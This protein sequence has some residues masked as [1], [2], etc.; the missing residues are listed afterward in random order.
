[1][2]KLNHIAF[3]MDG[4]GRWGEKKKRGRNFGHV[5]GV[6]TIK[7]IVNISKIF[8]ITYNDAEK[9]KKSFNKSETEF[10]YTGKSKNNVITVNEIINKKISINLLKKVILYRIQEIIDLHFKLSN[11]KNYNINLK[12]T[13]LF[14]IGDGSILFDNNSFYLDNKF[15]FK[16]INYFSETDSQI[17]LSA[18]AQYL[19]EYEKPKI[20]IKNKGLFERFFFYF[21]K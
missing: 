4:N 6:E 16:S 9:I 15:E 14:L 3:I 18:I 2:N 17:C 19:S 8:K 20:N 11:I 12:E 1:M 21:S 10:S 7:K 13:D 5:K